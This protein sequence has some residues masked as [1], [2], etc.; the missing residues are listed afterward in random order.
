[1]L[2]L[3]TDYI[4]ESEAIWI[5]EL[6]TSP[7]VYIL[8]G[9]QEDTANAYIRRYIEPVV[10]KTSSYVRKTTANDKLLQYTLDIE[11]SKERVIQKA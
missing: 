3:N 5:E 2:K 4:S 8:N 11:R 10:V 6:F 7:E 9:Y 1:M